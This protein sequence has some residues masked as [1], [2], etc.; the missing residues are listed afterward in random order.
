V[1]KVECQSFSSAAFSLSLFLEFSQSVYCVHVFLAPKQID[2][3]RSANASSLKKEE[4]KLCTINK[5]Q[6]E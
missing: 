1:F 6:R 4:E 2:K 5:M 3:N